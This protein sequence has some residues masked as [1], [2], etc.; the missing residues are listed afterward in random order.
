MAAAVGRADAIALS[1]GSR[2]TV[3]TLM[4]AC[5]MVIVAGASSMLNSLRAMDRDLKV[6]NEQLAITNASNDVLNKT[7]DSMPPSSAHLKAVVGVVRLTSAEVKKSS[8]SINTLA[9]STTNLNSMLGDIA[10][11]TAAM[12]GSLESVDSGTTSLG[13]S[14]DT[15]NDRIDPL[16]ATQR[17][18]KYDLIKMR[19][20][21]EG[22]NGSLAYVIRTLHYLT[23]PPT[24]QGF[25]MQ[26]EVDKQSLP[27]IP[28]VKA[29]AD[30]VEVF[31]RGV[32]PIYN[33][34]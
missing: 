18:T 15:L 24:G 12:Q 29:K 3:S 33:G 1:I 34:L 20:G 23:A 22:M 19:G 4:V 6:I 27:P 5:V 26:V 2:I 16:A 17:K 13:A 28:G 8:A 11:Q 30:P 25:K 14:V 21:L 32:W 7:L 10:T 9:T 31:P